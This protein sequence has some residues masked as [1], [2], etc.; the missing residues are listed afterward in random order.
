MN[1]GLAFPFMIVESPTELLLD[2]SGC[3]SHSDFLSTCL[4]I[5]RETDDARVKECCL[6]VYM[7]IRDH[8]PSVVKNLDSNV[9]EQLDHEVSIANPKIIKLRRMVI[10]A[11]ARAA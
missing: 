9:R 4:K 2:F 1:Y 10:G 7:G 3:R 11:L 8:Y 5:F 6:A